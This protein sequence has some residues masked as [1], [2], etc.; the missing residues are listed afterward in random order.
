MLISRHLATGVWEGNGILAVDKARP[1][2]LRGSTVNI[3][4][5]LPPFPRFARWLLSLNRADTFR[6]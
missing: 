2:P 6:T 1:D 5:F 4:H 3:G